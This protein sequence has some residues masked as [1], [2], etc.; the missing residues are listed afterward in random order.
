MYLLNIYIFFGMKNEVQLMES[1]TQTRQAIT[2]G[3][4]ALK[5]HEITPTLSAHDDMHQQQDITHR[6]DTVRKQLHSLIEKEKMYKNEI[7]DLKQ[8]LSR[9]YFYNGRKIK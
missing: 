5:I 1:A 9:R 8:Q 7:S 3:E 4:S 6:T 2:H